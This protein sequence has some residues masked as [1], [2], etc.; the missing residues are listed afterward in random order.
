MRVRRDMNI[1]Q[2][3]QSGESVEGREDRQLRQFDGGLEGC[4][5]QTVKIV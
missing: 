3:R 1:R 5:D 4:E 2:L